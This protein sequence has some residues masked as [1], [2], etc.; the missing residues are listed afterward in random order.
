MELLHYAASPPSR[1]AW[2]EIMLDEG[3]EEAVQSPPSRGAWIEIA[4]PL[5]VSLVVTLSPPSRGRGLK[6]QPQGV[7]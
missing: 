6:S 3:K 5:Q 7:L 1:G 4:S 2:I